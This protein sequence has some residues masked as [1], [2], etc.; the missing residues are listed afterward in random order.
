[1]NKIVSLTKVLIKNSFQKYNENNKNKNIVGKVILYILLGAYLMGIFAFLSYGLIS[2]L[3]QANQESMFIGIFLLG[4]ALLTIIQSIISATNVFYFSK[5]IEYILPLP[6]KPKEILISKLNVIL[7][8]E[9]IMEIIF[10]VTPI[11]IYGII[12]LQ[13]PMFYIISLLVLIVFPIIPILIAT[14]II[15]IIMSFSKRFKNKDRFRLIAPLIGIILAVIMSFSLSGTT[16]YSEEDL[17]NSLKQ[18]NSMVE[19]VSDNLPIIKPAINA[20]VNSSFV[21]FL[22][23]LGITLILYIVFILIGNKIYFRGVIGNLSSGTKK[24]KEV[25]LKKIKTNSI[26]KS[27]IIKEFKVL[28]KNPIFF[29]QCVLP[30]VLMPIIFLGIFI[31]TLNTN[32]S[33]EA[34]NEFKSVLGIYIETPIGL[35]IIISVTEFLTSMLYIAPTVISRDGQ[36]AI[37]MKY[38]PISYYKQLIYKGIPNIFFGTITS[39]IVIAFIY[40]LAKPSLLFL[41]TVFIINLILLILQT[42]LM[43]LVDL[44]KPKLEWTTEYAVVKQNLNLLWPVVLNLLEVGIIFII[45]ILLN[46][47]N[48]LLTAIILIV[49]HIIITYF[50]NKYMYKNQNELFNKIG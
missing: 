9:Y 12:T 21:E 43:E 14:F 26:G 24:G 15:M 40:I 17:L 23:L 47:T 6:L 1:M 38:I 34:L 32:N 16:N 36:N 42:L 11:T 33:Q 25:K 39:T 10:A 22:K 44:R 20:I 29:I 35:A 28:L 46:F 37:F 4:L 19:M 50:V 31:V 3:K 13:G 45:S 41:L 30:S 7:I 5:D 2:T 8:T 18:A 48:Y 27:Y 49:I